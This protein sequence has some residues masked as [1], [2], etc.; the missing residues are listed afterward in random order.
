MKA[1]STLSAENKLGD[2]SSLASH[3]AELGGQLSFRLGF[4]LF[5]LALL[6][7]LVGIGWGLPNA[8]Q[9]ES[10]HPDEPVVLAY[11]QQIEPA[12]FDFDP[13]FYNYGT[14]YLTSVR[15]VTK[16]VMGYSGTPADAAGQAQLKSS[17]YLAARLINVV[18]GAVA[19]WAVFTILARRTHWVGA[20]VGG[21]L[22]A[23]APALLV[24]S[25]FATVDIFAL[26]FWALALTYCDK[27]VTGDNTRPV[28]DAAIAGILIG[29][30]A[31]TKYLGILLI[32]A[33]LTAMLGVERANRI[34][35]TLAGIAATL[36]AF[37]LATPGS[38]TNT[39]AFL[40]DFKFE[41][42]HTA[43]G[44]G[45]VFE[46]TPIGFVQQM[47]NVS[48]SIGGLAFL[49]GLLGV[50]VA[51][52]RKER[53][54]VPALVA[55][56]LLY[57]VIGR[58]EVKFVRYCFPLIPLFALG[59]G[60]LAGRS[61]QAGDNRGRFVAGMTLFALA[62]LGGGGLITG[63]NWSLMMANRDPRNLAAEYL[64]QE[65]GKSV[66]LV[67]DPWFYTPTLYPT[68]AMG[69]MAGVK[70][71]E[72]MAATSNPSVI[73]IIPPD[74]ETRR[75]WD[76]ALLAA[77]PDFI[78]ISSFEMDDLNRVRVAKTAS[79]AAMDAAVRMKVFMDMMEKSYKLDMVF[80]Q[81]GPRDHDL[82]YIQPVIWIW[83]RSTS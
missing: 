54:I 52:A 6:L 9:F 65:P 80:G 8:M 11:A 46:A 36:I 20:A 82:M 7:R 64:R 14:L 40:R 51:V 83:K 21:G 31:G 24:H 71:F 39:A 2:K 35:A 37:V 43:T 28:R 10:L 1:I 12:S 68:S 48:T 69:P 32:I 62:G 42:A 78:A 25:R 70:R 72:D 26:G 74:P 67:S 76:P 17:V 55:T 23:V 38:I 15:I 59:L 30:G 16:V 13:G 58:A 75:D 27:L 22:M 57:L 19:A 45:F 66:G 5:L 77:K 33:L 81:G 18:F 61:H 49:L 50:G 34:K 73:R 60:S 56:L 41:M 4:G 3:L 29:L 63:V 47:A 44:H 53:W 79:P